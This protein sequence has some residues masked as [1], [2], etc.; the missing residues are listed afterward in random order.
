MLNLPYKE[1]KEHIMEKFEIEYL[2]HHLKQNQGNISKTAENCG[3]DR[4]SIHRLIK[5]IN[6]I[7]EN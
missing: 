3:M 4:R 2:S 7:Y 6:I 1:A 5:K